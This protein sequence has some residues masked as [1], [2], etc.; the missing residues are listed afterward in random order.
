MTD[1]VQQLAPQIWQAIQNANNILLHCH[2]SPDPD[3]FGSTLA[4]FHA[5]K[6]INKKVTLIKGDSD[7]PSSAIALPGHDQITPKNFFEINQDEF[8]LFIIQDTAGL[9]QIS[10]MKPITFPQSMNTILI[11][12]HTTNPGFANINLIDTTYPA[13]CQ[14][15]FDL[16]KIWQ[17]TITKDIAS[18]LFLGL[19]TDTGGF[20]YSP[21][22]EST[23]LAAAEL[24]KINPDFTQIIFNWENNLQPEHLAYRSLALN[25]IELFFNNHVALAATSFEDLQKKGIRATHT[26]KSEISNALI[27]V[28]GW[29]IGATLTETSPQTVNMSFRTR[30]KYD[31]SKI[32]S[33]LGGG[34]HPAAAGAT[35]KMSLPEAKKN[36]LEVIHKI[37]PYL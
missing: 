33:A 18:C 3:S 28:N 1:K 5:L 36:L 12:H 37:Y 4:M 16:F 19:Y 29:E 14:I 15:I 13:T 32:A 27:S 6:S 23:F 31:V 11:D 26:E 24:A 20:K 17:I 7:I 9:T 34:G 2:P 8:D 25:S 21:A 10:K 30:G 35:V 22:N